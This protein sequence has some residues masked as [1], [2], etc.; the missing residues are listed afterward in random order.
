VALVAEY[1]NGMRL[2]YTMT[3]VSPQGERRLTFVGTMGEIRCELG[4]YRIEY[5]R[6]PDRPPEVIQ[7]PRPPG[8]GHQ[9]HDL[10]L[11]DD[12]LQRIRRGDDPGA[13]IQDAYMSGAVAFAALESMST[14]Q[15]VSVPA[16]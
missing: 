7:V 16:L 8:T 9:H 12:F 3:M 6:L 13:G 10:A 4:S 1:S 11:L 14:G 5:W 15:I 2:S